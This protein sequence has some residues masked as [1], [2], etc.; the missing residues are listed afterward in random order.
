MKYGKYRWKLE[1]N[2]AKKMENVLF[3]INQEILGKGL[4]K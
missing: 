4:G 2:L 1:I 3:P